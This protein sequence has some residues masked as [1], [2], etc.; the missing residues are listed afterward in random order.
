M[1]PCIKENGSQDQE[2]RAKKMVVEFRYGQMD[3][4]TMDSGEMEWPMG[5]VV[6]FTLRAMSMKENGPKTKQ[7]VTVYI[8]TLMEAGMRANGS[9]ISNTEVALKNGQMVPNTKASTSK[10]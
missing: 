2:A 10:E 7:M 5:M 3:R 1:E 9:Q 8:L 6:W 4:D